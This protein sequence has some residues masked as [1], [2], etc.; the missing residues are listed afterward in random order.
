VTMISN[1]KYIHTTSFLGF[2]KQ[3]NSTSL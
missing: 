2:N 3:N 1:F